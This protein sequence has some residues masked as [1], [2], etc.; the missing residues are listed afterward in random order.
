MDG[1]KRGSGSRARMAGESKAN[2]EYVKRKINVPTLCT[3]A[4]K[5]YSISSSSYTTSPLA[6]RKSASAKRHNCLCSP[7]THVGSF[8][9]RYHRNSGLV[10]SGMPVGSKLLDLTGKPTAHRHSSSSSTYVPA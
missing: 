8:R 3:N 7:T 4:M 6:P 10:H 1:S 2:V 9:C 5:T